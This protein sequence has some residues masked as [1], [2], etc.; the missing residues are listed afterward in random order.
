MKPFA[1][2]ILISLFCLAA[3]QSQQ[4]PFEALKAEAERLY[5]EA[6]YSRA[7][8]IYLKAR[9][10]KLSP[11]EARWVEF[12]L[13]DVLW[14]AQAATQTADTTIYETAQQ[15]LEAIIRERPRTEDHDRTWAEAQES[16]GDLWWTRR[17]VKDWQKAWPHYQQALDWWAGTKDLDLGR[18][19]YLKIV[20]TMA[21]P[22]EA[23]SY[24]YY[25]YNG[26][27]APIEILDNALKIARN[28]AE[29]AYAHYLTAMTLSNRGGDHRQRQRTLEEFEAAIK[30]G[31]ASEWFDDAL[32]H[33]GEWM[34]QNGR[35][36]PLDDG[37]WR[38][39][40]DY[41]KALELFRR[42]VTEYGKG[43]TR[44]YDQAQQQIKFITQ[45]AFGVTVANIFLP[46]S[47]IQ[48]H[49]SWR[50]LKRVELAL[51]PVN[52]PRDLQISG[53]KAN[54][55]DWIQQIDLS[56]SKKLQEWNKETVD[57]GDYRPREET[58][59]LS[60]KLPVGAYVIEARNGDVSARDLLLVTDTALVLKASGKQALAY[61]C[62]A[63][64]GAPLSGAK[65]KLGEQYYDGKETVWRESVKETNQDG[66]AL[67]DL[68][69][70]QYHSQLIAVAAGDNR[71]AFSHG[72]SQS[73]YRDQ[74]PWRIYAF[75][76]RPAYRPNEIAQWKFIAR[77][78]QGSVYSTPARQT[79]EFDISDPHGAKVKEGKAELNAFGS[80]WGSLDLTESMPLGEYRINFYDVGRKNNIGQAA[81]FRLEE[82]K[83]PEFQVKVQTP[84]ENGRKKAFR[85]G[86]KVEANIQ[87][88]Y[89]FGGPVA[90]ATV[91]V[92]V[93]QNWFHHWWYPERDFQWYYEDL[94][95]R[96]WDGGGQQ[97]Q[98][99]KRE[100]IRTDATGK[101][102]IAF[103]TPRDIEQD[104]E[105]QIEA[106]VADSS[107]H[108]IVGA[109]S[110]RVT[111]Q[112][113]YLYPR[114]KHNL[115]RPQ[116]KVAVDLKA[117]DANNQPMQVEGTIKVTRDTWY[118]IWLD[119]S[120]REVKGDELKKLREKGE[121]PHLAPQGAAGWRLKFRGYQSDDILTQALKTNAEGEAE[122]NFTPE[123]EGYY[124]V[125]WSSPD[126]GAA[127]IKAET[128]VWVTANA[129][130]ELGY[131]HGGLELIVDRDTFRAGQR[132]PVML[133]TP[134]PG[135]YVLFSVETENLESYQLAHLTGTVKLIE[136]P[137]E[138]RHTPNIF[139]SAAMVSDR[140]I[141]MNAKQIFVPPAQNFLAVEVK[142][143][144]E[145]Y[146]SR[147]EGVITVTT[148]DH[149]GHP[150]SAEV[151][152]GLADESVYYI[153]QDYAAD[154]RRFYYG[155][156]RPM[157][158]QTQSTFQQ[159]S[160]AKLVEGE[161]K[162][163]VEERERISMQQH[164]YEIGWQQGQGGRQLP[165]SG[166]VSGVYSELSVVTRSGAVRDQ[167]IILQETEDA[168]SAGAVNFNL[169]INGRSL[170]SL[171][172]F[173]RF[174]AEFGANSA[175]YL[176][177]SGQEP[178]VQV[179]SD[180]RST[181]FWQP[182]VVT[183]KDG[184]AVVKV[185]F[186]D[187]LTRWKA[188]ARVATEGNQFGVA[189]ATTRTKQ[190]L[191]ARLQAPR[192][193][194]AGDLA[195]VS[196]VIN[197][198]TD[199]PMIVAPLLQ[200]EGLTVTGLLSDGKPIKGGQGPVEVKANGEARVDWAVVAQQPG[201]A[202]LKVTARGDKYADAM[203]RDF[204][205]H[206]HGIEKL[207][208]RSGK[209]RGADVIVK[210]DLP[211]ERNRETT[212]LTVQISPSL[213]VT[214]LDALPYLIDYPYGCTEQTMSRFLPA[215]I[216][217]KTLKDMGLS[218]ESVMSRMF[219][220]IEQEHASKTHPK[221]KKDLRQLDD[222]IKKGLDRLYNFQHADGG[223]GWWKEGDSDH[224]MTAYVVWGLTLAREAGVQIKTD[225]LESGAK[226][227]EKEI[228]E[229]ET[230][231]DQQSW[232]LHA[233]AAYHISSKRREVGPFQARAFDNLWT[234]REKLNAYA[235][236][237]LALSAHYFGYRDRAKTLVHNLED[238]VKMDAAPDISIVRTIPS[239]TQAEALSAAHWGED[240]LYSRWSDGGVEATSFALRALLAVEP[241]HKLIEPVANWL[242]K[243]RRGAQWS[244]TRD[245]A[246]TV[247]ALNDYLR[248]S[249]ELSADLEYE[250]LFNGQRIVANKITA[251]D[252][253]GA[254]NRFEI[255]N[256]RREL[257]SDGANDIRIRR[258]S[259]NSPI[260]FSAEA[261]FF[262]REEPITEAGNEI[263]VRRQY[264]KLVARPTL[265]KGYVY[266][267]ELLGNGETMASGER[268]EAVITIEAKNNYEYLLFEDLKPAGL[269]AVEL[270]S[271][272]ALYARELKSGAAARKFAAPSEILDDGA[273]QGELS[274]VESA[275]YTGRQ[276]WVYQELRDRKVAL[277]IDKLSEGVWEV[278]Y[279]M[280]AE[281]PGRFHALPVIGHA[282]YTPEICG[283]GVETRLEVLP[284]Q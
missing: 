282:M 225:A 190:P 15:Q 266:D 8:E 128:A 18:A 41:V 141:F 217:A 262:S 42:L 38:Q 132:A 176:Q 178:A 202:K 149:Q 50:N 36:V 134:A 13:A 226:F 163:L 211:K 223:W 180:F 267:R 87:V 60:G 162:K 110:V 20:W 78:Y 108:E 117:L 100:K 253:L 19:R 124:R 230:R 284:S 204:I 222:M 84:E 224:F 244:N 80:A 227:L 156:K 97:G 220:G 170:Q 46:D 152:L 164:K 232:M 116:D 166:G 210:L 67:F 235:R 155:V 82:Y 241:D 142:T 140:Q 213:A 250:L 27:Y 26:A 99:I 127:P 199:Q 168:T 70:A 172:G 181:I 195:T 237:L 206:E 16:L 61:F 81:L 246:I 214:M 9:A 174:D 278:R 153:Q 183:D 23:D 74:Q 264:Y 193:F 72:Y 56:R 37:G 65:V 63:L 47:E 120:G 159:K 148:R 113:Y 94:M 106:R 198:N 58:I 240:G 39:E 86:D 21:Q 35:Y 208:A 271:G 115:H 273:G 187:S 91:E 3:P 89:Y 177:P 6:S 12:R 79:I 196:A 249:G 248:S 119:P 192:F 186:P 252:A 45:P 280:R 231:H 14:R 93:H 269:E 189:S 228:V 92:V 154:P 75:T 197:N 34:I 123:R 191:M 236:A 188:M 194:V 126:K 95:P 216:T 281:T 233:L 200:A 29:R 52:L 169:P 62:N 161:D 185:K 102:T 165:I 136:V 205:V 43:E 64:S 212:R 107:R 88:D 234:N 85:L 139:L 272:S 265:L 133:H 101:A 251:A 22:P 239:R 283:N 40:Q 147:E 76:D 247:L 257:L 145:Q 131:R 138:E 274:P 173:G 7:Q 245:T 203:E 118:E 157:L 279:Q 158:V 77:K 48:I 10:I 73:N 260:Y 4:T 125:A 135:R 146:E 167:R 68:T 44:Y 121:F 130:T 268:V 150:V 270:R 160:Y 215:A 90:N 104:F 242:I 137:I 256:L 105:Y 109:G 184:A 201:P 28:D 49:L 96:Y 263:F 221:G 2:L 218:P 17:N 71:Q 243:N 219:G 122:F 151:A 111:R 129:T 83:L 112:R 238:G 103:D 175:A 275:N 114:A 25:G 229:E 171:G 57:N 98:I 182:D 59:R 69:G 31:K 259:G 32:Y 276:R 143:D 1:V 51:Y 207:V 255:H 5:V 254:P 66:I 55:G 24:Y 277:F 54:S 261:R 53:K 144:R 33:Y 11:E 258:L 209:L 179:R 30:D